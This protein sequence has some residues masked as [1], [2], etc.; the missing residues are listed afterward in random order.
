MKLLQTFK[1]SR[2]LT[3]G[4]LCGELAFRWKELIHSFGIP[5][6]LIAAPA[7]FDWEKFNVVDNKGE[8]LGVEF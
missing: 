4:K 1:F 8:V 3:A 2:L 6:Y 7:A 5:E